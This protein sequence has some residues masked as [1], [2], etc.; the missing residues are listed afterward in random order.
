MMKET[1]NSSTKA[2]TFKAFVT[3]YTKKQF[4][5]A[6]FAHIMK[7]RFP[8]IIEIIS[9]SNK[10]NWSGFAFLEFED[11]ETFNALM[12]L[13]KINIDELDLSLIFNEYKEGEELQNFLDDVKKRKLKIDKIPL[14][15]TDEKLKEYFSTFGEI[16]TVFIYRKIRKKQRYHQGLIT[17]V[18]IEDTTK[19]SE[20]KKLKIEGSEK[21]LVV[22]RVADIRSSKKN[23]KNDFKNESKKSPIFSSK[24]KNKTHK[25]TYT[26]NFF[27]NMG[28]L[29]KE[30]T[31]HFKV[32][33]EN[34][35]HLDHLVKP[36]IK[37][38]FDL[39]KSLNEKI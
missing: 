16:E 29:V 5:F 30:E 8:K 21:Y 2:S 26:R 6:E 35:S 37:K 15:W 39:R 34:L 32:T 11:E 33:K 28:Y 3:G 4:E 7:K 19:V 12:N 31:T 17:F 36:T 27:D 38:Y 10:K 9:P 24:L 1:V 14:K 23:I 22:K 13:K 18:S 25:S 20:M